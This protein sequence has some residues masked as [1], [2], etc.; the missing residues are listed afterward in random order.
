MIGGKGK[1]TFN[2]HGNV[3]NA[4]YDYKTDSNFVIHSHKTDNQI[5][6]NPNANFYD[7][8]GFNYNSYRLPLLSF[9]YNDDDKFIAGIGY[10]LKTYGFRK[11]PYSTFQSLTSVVSFNTGRYQVHY[12]GE[13][14]QVILSKYDVL[15]T[16]SLFNTVL[17]N[18]F[19]LGNETKIDKSQDMNFY[20]VRYNY[21]SGDILLRKRFHKLAELSFGP[22]YYH[23]WNH[24]YDNRGK[25]LSQPAL[26]GL[27]SSNIYS[28]KTYVGPK[29]SIIIHNLNNDLFP[30]RGLY[31]TT[32]LTSLFG[33]NDDSRQLTKLTTDMAVYASYKDPTRLVTVLRFGYGHIFSKN[34]E[35]FQALDLG[36]NNYLRGFRKNR[37]AGRSM[38]YESTEFRYKLFDSKS[39]ILPGAVGLLAFNDV[40]RVWVK[41]QT[42]HK[43][44]DSF[45]GGLYYSPYNFFIVSGMIAFSSE[46]SLLNFSIGTKVNIT[47]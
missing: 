24:Y 39:Y 12:N 25:I 37:F 23:Y 21:L 38:M 19:G 35:Y 11:D 14:N 33:I 2:I 40:G 4:V 34:Y 5:N 26:T 18:Y 41:D 29:V 17:N 30:T 1:D 45:G 8:T 32:E 10:S 15:A 47:Y 13:F 6:T 27:D 16:G 31:W 3:R 36:A 20:K 28:D 7:I 9:S 22:S 46:S 43:W 44:H 42:S